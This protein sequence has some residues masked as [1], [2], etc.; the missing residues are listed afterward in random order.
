MPALR[1]S[2]RCQEKLLK[3][4]L[5]CHCSLAA[6]RVLYILSGGELAG[7]VCIQSQ[8]NWGNDIKCNKI[9]RNL[10]SS[11][12]SLPLQCFICH[13]MSFLRLKI[14]VSK[15]SVERSDIDF[16][17]S[18]NVLQVIKTHIRLHLAHSLVSKRA[19]FLICGPHAPRFG[20]SQSIVCSPG[21]TCP[22][23]LTS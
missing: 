18:L 4:F 13:L 11:S 14:Q 23:S 10:F 7:L 1:Q 8:A 9:Q 6:G 12:L 21:L 5:K 19:P 20:S 22:S 15:L 2:R 3:L 16:S 17:K